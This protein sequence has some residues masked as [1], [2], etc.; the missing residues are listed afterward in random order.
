MSYTS[1][2]AQVK[3]DSSLIGYWPFNSNMNDESEYD[4]HGINIDCNLVSDNNEIVDQAYEFNGETSYIEIPFSYENLTI[5][6]TVSAWIYKNNSNVQEHIFSSSSENGIYNGIYFS[7]NSDDQVQ[8]TY[9]DGGITSSSSRRTKNSISSIPIK[10]WTHVVAVVYGPT[11]MII[12]INSSIQ[13]GIYSGSGGELSNGI[14]HALI[15]RAKPNINRWSGVLDEV[16]L[17]NRALTA[18][19]LKMICDFRQTTNNQ[20]TVELG[21]LKIYPNPADEFIN[22]EGIGEYDNYTI[23]DLNGKHLKSG[24]IK[25]ANQKKVDISNLNDGQYIL[26]LY[27]VLRNTQKMIIIIK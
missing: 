19:E 17:Y 2:K 24:S 20:F 8:I 4:N 1:S 9:T 27:G 26:S 15:G 13:D 23:H 16:R 3:L 21:Y 14:E 10:T 12:Q 18:D 22:I 5:P 6:F 25:S 11:D 7:V